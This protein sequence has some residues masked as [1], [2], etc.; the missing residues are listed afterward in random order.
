MTAPMPSRA[1]EPA[2]PPAVL[3]SPS[4]LAGEDPPSAASVARIA[5]ARAAI[6]AILHGQDSKRLLVVAGPC[7]IH[8]PAAALEYAG[9]IAKV[10]EATRDQLVVVMRTYF[11]KPRTCAGWKGLINDPYLDGTGDVETGLRTARALLG[12][13]N[14]LG[15]PC[16][17]ELLDPISA[18]YICDQLSWAAIGARTAESQT[19]REL[20]SAMP[21]PIGIKN[22]THGDVDVAVHAIAAAALQ[23]HMLTLDADGRPAAIRSDGNADCALVL[24]GSVERPNYA[25]AD[26]LAALD[27]IARLGLARPL[28]IDCSHDNSRRD[29]TRQAVVARSVLEQFAGG[30]RAIMGILLESNLRPGRQ[31]LEPGTALE[32]GVSVTDGCMGWTE[33]EALLFEAAE[34]V[35]R[36]G[37]RRY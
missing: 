33:T 16:G 14:D 15:L 31:A 19:H 23:H 28:V 6:R 25:P 37:A 24:R 34:A 2:S 21:M 13:I 8:D 7:S 29:Y 1:E 12:Q 27:C 26:L 4:A 20:A 36:A 3:P 30:Q 9:A 18:R 35:E 5:A 22:P 17:A 10:A 32:Y 11:D